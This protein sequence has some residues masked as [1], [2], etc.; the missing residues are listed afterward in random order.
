MQIITVAPIV[1][2]ALKEY[3]TYFSKDDI[4]VGMIVTVP[5]RAREIP[6]IVIETKK[7]TDAK[8]FLKNSD[9]AIRK[10]THASPRR[11]WLPEFLKAVEETA[12]FSAQKLGPAL[13]S[14][15][16]KSILDAHLAGELDKPAITKNGTRFEVLAIQSNTHERYEEYRKRI[17]ES[18]ARNE[19]VFV[20]VPTKE[21]ALGAISA[22][23]HGIESYSF[24]FHSEMTKKRITELWKDATHKEHAVL[25]VGTA[26]YLALPRSFK[27]IIL[28]EEHSPSWKTI[29]TPFIDLRF[30]V[31]EYA[32]ESKS[33]LIIGSSL[34]RAETHEKIKN[35][36]VGEFGRIAMHARSEIGTMLIDPR[37]EEKKI[38]EYSGKRELVLIT[39]ELKELIAKTLKQNGHILLLTARKG[40][41]PITTCGDCGTIVRCPECDTPLVIHKKESS[42]GESR[43]FVCHGCGFIRVP[44]N[45][46]NETCPNCGGWKLQGI[47]IGIDLVTKEISTLFPE[48]VRFM[49]D[50]DKAKTRTQAKKIIDQFEKSS[51]G[52]LIATVMAIPFLKKIENTGIISIDSLFAIPDIRISERIFALVLALREKTTQTLLIQTRGDDTSIFEQAL[53][54]NLSEFTKNELALRKMF[55]Y[56]PYATIVKITLRGK[57]SEI[58]SEMEQL[59]MYLANYSPVVP[60][61]IAREPKNIFRMHM[62]LKLAKDSWPNINLRAKLLALPSQ[63]S[64]EVNP[65]NL[66]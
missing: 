45:N 54:G 63:F 13:L 18:F 56:P 57:R 46:V 43:L 19:S 44:E 66:I 10:I 17:R 32:K 41:A 1:R 11:I 61:T 7:V 36:D 42:N 20:C 14:L 64:I 58:L 28:D 35:G 8:T 29:S 34:L 5:L 40:L 60:G 3:L 52:I 26:Q 48:A 23:G 21:D 2:G 59:K 9:Y 22:L 49:L 27:T 62:L 65:D 24:V 4:S 6:G 15:T 12:N 25:V 55:S 30:F 16:P 37:K 50:G 39:T 47:G 51:S 38:K 53:S 33:T 31:E